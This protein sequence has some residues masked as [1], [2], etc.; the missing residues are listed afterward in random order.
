MA[1][2]RWATTFGI[3]CEREHTPEEIGALRQ[4]RSPERARHMRGLLAAR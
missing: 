1:N 2:P 3:G 4:L